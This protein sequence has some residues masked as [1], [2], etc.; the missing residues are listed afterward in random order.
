[1][2]GIC[3]TSVYNQ[4]ANWSSNWLSDKMRREFFIEKLL[5]DSNM[6]EHTLS[7]VH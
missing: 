6:Q 1:M 2:T 3:S 5:S 7:M 4:R